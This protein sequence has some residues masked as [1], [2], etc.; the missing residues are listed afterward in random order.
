MK[1]HITHSLV[2]E[3]LNDCCSVCQFSTL[4]CCLIA[5]N[6]QLH[7]TRLFS[8]IPLHEMIWFEY[9]VSTQTNDNESIPFPCIH[10]ML[11][12]FC[13]MTY[14]GWLSIHCP[15]PAVFL[16][17]AVVKLVIQSGAFNLSENFFSLSCLITC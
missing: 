16:F 10:N 14:S 2:M 3:I 11:C 12:A 4:D 1:A 7:K 8:L 5:R 6:I 15:V 9:Q 17:M 13:H